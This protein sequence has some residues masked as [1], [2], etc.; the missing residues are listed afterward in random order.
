M[1]SGSD[2]LIVIPCLNE[3][4]ML[5]GLLAWLQREH[6]DALVVVADGG[7]RDASRSIVEA[8]MLAWPSLRLL[9]NPQRFQ[10]AGVNLAA[11][12]FGEGRKWLIRIDAHAEYPEDYVHLL[13]AAALQHGVE[14]VV[15]PMVTTGSG[16]FQ[17]A[18]A[19]GQNSVLGTG[20]SP[21][22]HVGKGSFVDHGHHALMR[23]DSFLAVDGYDPTFSHNE[24]AELDF[25]LRASGCRIWLEPGAV[26]HYHP[27]STAKALL[28]QYFKFGKG[29]ARTV[30]K[31]RLSLKVR[32]A[33]PLVVVPA[34]ITGLLAL[35]VSL[36][37]PLALLLAAPAVGWAAVCQTAG[38]V[39]A[40][41]DRCWCALAAGFAIMIMHAAWS[42]GYWSQIVSPSQNHR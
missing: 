9:E 12:A 32:Q 5:P 4:R 28:T 26:V 42:L 31:H 18:A 37:W 15:V 1:I 19:A 35:P 13:I 20:G 25:R 24:D 30:Q 29:R 38:I 34:V 27:R 40:L 21:H 8:A 11:R 2:I 22:R 23:L 3:E 17:V 7:S 39:L 36:Y 14:S 33:L 41:R 6:V 16:C 10:S